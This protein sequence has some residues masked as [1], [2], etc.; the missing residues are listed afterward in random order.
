[1][2]IQ[3]EAPQPAAA[4]VR[5]GLALGGG[6]ELGL[7]HIG[8]LR[9][10]ER[11]GLI[12]SYLAGSSAGALAAAFYAAGA[13]VA[14]MRR[15]ATRL[16]WRAIQRLTIPVL[17][18][19]TNEP[20]R[21]FLNCMLPVRDFASLRI[22]LRL[23]TTD[24]LTAEMV[25]FE[26]GPPFQPQGLIADPD[27][28]FTTGDLVEAIRASCARPVI[29]KPVKLGGRLLVDGC[30][31]NNVPAMLVR[32]MGADVVVAV[33][34]TQKRLRDAPPRNILSYAAQAQAIQLHW[35]LKSRHIAADVI[36]R[37]D[38]SGVGPADFA[39]ADRITRCGE[40]AAE[41]ALP[42]IEEALAGRRQ[43]AESRSPG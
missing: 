17:A 12:P 22:P 28:I 42:L 5:M 37:P 10:L 1:M 23:V 24:L 19:S 27:V 41:A 6:A 16:T 25:V 18:L 26:G 43:S 39:A 11:H 29:N 40:T 14:K 7:A 20:L 9:I 3:A 36:I 31:T 38:F 35:A 2:A 33:D 30:L 4:R 15:L 13:S 32:D 8:V 21:A 34:L